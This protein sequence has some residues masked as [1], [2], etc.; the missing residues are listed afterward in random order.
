MSVENL[1]I[2]IIFNSFLVIFCIGMLFYIRWFRN[3]QLKEIKD[4][5]STC[6]Q[7]RESNNPNETL[8]LKGIKEKCEEDNNFFS[9]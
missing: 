2:C 1:I 4:S 8:L 3:N 7:S 6:T 5:I 9:I